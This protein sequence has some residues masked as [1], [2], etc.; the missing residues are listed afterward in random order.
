MNPS[1]YQTNYVA[2]PLAAS[3]AENKQTPVKDDA[4]RFLQSMYRGDFKNWGGKSPNMKIL[5]Q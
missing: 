4:P 2:H 3:Q 5:P 1:N